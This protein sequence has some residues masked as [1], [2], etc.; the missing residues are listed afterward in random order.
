MGQCKKAYCVWYIGGFLR[1]NE[2]RK[3]VHCGSLLKKAFIEE[4]LNHP[5]IKPGY[6]F[7]W[8]SRCTLLRFFEIWQSPNTAA[9]IWVSHGYNGYPLTYDTELEKR[10]PTP[11]ETKAWCLYP[12]GPHA[13]QKPSPNLRALAV[14]CCQSSFHTKAWQK[15]IG[16][17][18]ALKTFVGILRDTPKAWDG[19]TGWLKFKYHTNRSWSADRGAR[20]LLRNL[21]FVGPCKWPSKLS[22]RSSQK[23]V[24]IAT[25]KIYNTL[26][27]KGLQNQDFWD[28]T[29]RRG[30]IG[31][32]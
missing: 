17:I 19:V 21:R 1:K 13:L 11:A 20:Y 25:T 18:A 8:E 7:H 30:P 2:R 6:H 9:I 4:K 26:G 3:W 5:S 14:V 23:D 29:Q 22:V 12:D 27:P 28:K 32:G 15:K 24:I 31:I 16:K 10:D